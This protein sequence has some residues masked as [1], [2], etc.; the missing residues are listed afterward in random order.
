MAASTATTTAGY[1]RLS[2]P[3]LDKL[4]DVGGSAMAL[5]VAILRYGDP[6]AGMPTIGEI[7]GWADLN[8]N[9]VGKYLRKLQRAGLIS[10]TRAVVNQ[11]QVSPREGACRLPPLVVARPPGG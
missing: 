10:E 5:Y 4:V 7:S 1:V 3:V 2:V 9:T 11:Q 8:R 6:A